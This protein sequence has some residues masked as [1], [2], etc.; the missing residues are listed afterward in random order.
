MSDMEKNKVAAAHS[1]P[2]ERPA[3]SRLRA[4]LSYRAA[5]RRTCGGKESSVP[6]TSSPVAHARKRGLFCDAP[7][8]L[9]I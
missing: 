3:K 7:L 4:S 6:Q 2:M 5:H 9:K 1:N 8:G